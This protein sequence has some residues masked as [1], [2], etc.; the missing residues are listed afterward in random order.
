M[1]NC[2]NY[3]S[4]GC[5]GS[6]KKSSSHWNLIDWGVVLRME[7]RKHLKHVPGLVY[8]QKA[9]ENGHR[10][11]E[12]SHEKWWFSIVM[13]V[14][15]P[16]GKVQKKG[17]PFA[18]PPLHCR[19]IQVTVGHTWGK[20]PGW[21][22]LTSPQSLGRCCLGIHRKSHHPKWAPLFVGKKNTFPNHIRFQIVQSPWTAPF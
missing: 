17:P 12:F 20:Q 21:S 7:R 11:S 10:N 2:L 3:T 1:L 6:Q 15:L 16:K 14:S 22:L 13:S 4:N 18:I 19:C 5:P 9:I 8:I